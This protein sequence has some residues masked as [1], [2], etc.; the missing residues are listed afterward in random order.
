MGYTHYM[1]KKRAFTDAEWKLFVKKARSIIVA[2]AAILAGGDGTGHPVFSPSAVVFNGRGDD[3]HETCYVGKG[4]SEFDFCKTARK[5]YD[6]TVVAIYKLVR[7]VLGPDGINISSDGGPEV[8]DGADTVTLRLVLE[9]KVKLDGTEL[10]EIESN[11]DSAARHLLEQGLVTGES[12]AVVE[13]HSIS[14]LKV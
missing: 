12:P 11:L 14:V 2:H 6:S 9:V 7:E 13:Q 1:S 3:S 8:F 10:S 4:A 5:P